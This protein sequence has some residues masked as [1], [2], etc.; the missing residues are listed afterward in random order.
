MDR[1]EGGGIVNTDH[2]WAG[3]VMSW[4]RIVAALIVVNLLFVA[5]TLVGLVVF[6]F[7]PAA[8]AA[9]ACLTRLRDGDAGP[10]LVREFVA[11]YHA[12]FW[13]ANLI[14]LPFL[15]VAGLLVL[16]TRVLA[17]L[18]GPGGAALT[19]FTWVVGI[20]AELVF[21]SALTAAVRYDETAGAV[22]RYAAVLP[23]TSPVMSLAMLLSLGAIGVAFALLPMLLPLV[24]ATVPLFVAGWFVDHRLAAIDPDHPRAADRGARPTTVAEASVSA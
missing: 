3:R 6:G 12:G 18:G 17:V 15:I 5:G 23:F 10:G 7:A 21:A 20:A 16:D 22:L 19:V 2:G 8:L 24:G 1:L 11:V 14:G 4:L 13:R 9:T